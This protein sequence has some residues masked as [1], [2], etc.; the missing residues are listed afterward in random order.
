VHLADRPVLGEPALARAL[1]DLLSAI[2]APWPGDPL[3][4]GRADPGAKAISGSAAFHLLII[5]DAKESARGKS[6]RGKSVGR[7][8][9][10]S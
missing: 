3:D 1:V 10:G 6:A 2:R 7:R 4:D 9:R 5:G 8:C